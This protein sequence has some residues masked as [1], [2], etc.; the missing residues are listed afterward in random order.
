MGEYFRAVNPGD[1][2]PGCAVDEAVEV[3]TYHGEVTCS[4]L[5]DVA[6]AR[7]GVGVVFEDV[8]S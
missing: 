4:G 7:G 6:A 8:A 1:A 2:L 3:D 5:G